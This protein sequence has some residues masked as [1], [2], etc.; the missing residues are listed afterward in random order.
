MDVSTLIYNAK[1][2][3]TNPAPELKLSSPLAFQGLRIG[4]CPPYLLLVAIPYLN[5]DSVSYLQEDNFTRSISL[6]IHSPLQQRI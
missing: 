4:L 6:Y 1:W 2:V 3:W 5:Y